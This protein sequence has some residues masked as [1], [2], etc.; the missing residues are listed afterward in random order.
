[1]LL[2]AK[3]ERIAV[4]TSS[5]RAAVVLIGLHL[6]EIRALALRETVLTIELK[7]RDFH[8]VLALA[9]YTGVYKNLRE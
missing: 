2:R 6:V 4:D 8:R 5:R 1:V 9:S 7:L 3:R